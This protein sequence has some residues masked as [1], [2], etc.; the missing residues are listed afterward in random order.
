VLEPCGP[1]PSNPES[2]GRFNG[3]TPGRPESSTD[4]SR[5]SSSSPEDRRRG[6]H[7]SGNGAQVRYT[8]DKGPHI[9]SIFIYDGQKIRK[10]AH[11]GDQIGQYWK[12]EITEGKGIY[13]NC[14]REKDKYPECALGMID[15]TDDAKRTVL[16]EKAIAYLCKEEQSVDPIKQ[17]GNE[18][19]FSRGIAPRKQSKAGRRRQ[20]ESTDAPDC[21]LEGESWGLDRLD[22]PDDQISTQND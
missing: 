11:K 6:N 22:S 16:K 18:R 3:K 1:Y 13:H 15:H 7:H 2:I 19:S 5:L 20:G 17:S 10:D 21:G 8:E 9:H 14:N 4:C 12:N